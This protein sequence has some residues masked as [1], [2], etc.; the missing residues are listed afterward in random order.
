[1]STAT[2]AEIDVKVPSVNA[3]D[4][5]DLM[6]SFNQVTSRLE[7]TH[8]KL[9]EEVVR[10]KGELHDANRELE[11]SRRLAAL[12]EM[13]AGIAHEVRNPLGSIGLYAGML[14]SDLVGQSEQQALAERIGSAVR[15]LDAIVNDVLVCSRE[16]R[17]HV[18]DVPVAMVLDEAIARCADLCAG[19]ESPSITVTDAGESLI[20]AADSSL[21]VQALT[22]VVRNAV[23]AAGEQAPEGGGRVALDVRT[24]AEF[25]D[26]SG[27]GPMVLIRVEDSGPG[28]TEEV[29]ERMFNP[30]FTTRATG[31]GLGLPIVHRIVEAHRGRVSVSPGG[32]FGGTRFDIAIPQACV[33]RAGCPEACGVE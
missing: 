10:L 32:Q 27:L 33:D 25:A 22:N 7:Q 11:R 28:V 5:A 13:A 12:G 4:L 19:D 30:F 15:G 14:V 16:L 3:G 8:C 2:H 21:L 26:D 18:E 1:M 23:E 24:S 20:V 6:E 29:T 31:T 17:V 9:R